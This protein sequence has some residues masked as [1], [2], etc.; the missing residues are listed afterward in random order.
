MTHAHEWRV[1]E[2]G[3][4]FC[5]GEKGC[6]AGDEHGRDWVERRLNATEKLGPIQARHLHEAISEDNW[7]PSFIG[8]LLDYAAALEGVSEDS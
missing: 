8:P 7:P 2:S 1:D 5:V 6:R 4:P 3:S